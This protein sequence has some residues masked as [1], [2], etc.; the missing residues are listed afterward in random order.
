MYPRNKYSKLYRISK[1]LRCLEV[2][3]TPI[4]SLHH[5]FCLLSSDPDARVSRVLQ[6]TNLTDSACQK[7]GNSSSKPRG[8]YETS[9]KMVAWKNKEKSSGQPRKTI[10]Q[11]K[12]NNC[13][14]FLAGDPLGVLFVT[15]SG[16]KSSPPFGFSKGHD[17][18][19]LVQT[20]FV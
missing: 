13:T 4:I 16:V 5:D 8:T 3:T 15:F 14:S 2:A 19:K 10:V 17:W 1:I 12:P 20:I 9:E 6:S 11:S 7:C 18:K